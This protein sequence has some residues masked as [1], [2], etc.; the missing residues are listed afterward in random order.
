MPKNQAPEAAEEAS[1]SEFFYPT[2]G[3]TVKAASKEEADAQ[4]AKLS[5]SA[6]A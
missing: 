5:I 2:V 6:N 1:L 3:V 4:V